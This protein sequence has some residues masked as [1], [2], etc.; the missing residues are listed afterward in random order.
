MWMDE[1]G[2]LA[3]C[4]WLVIWTSGMKKSFD[5]NIL[6]MKVLTP[7]VFNSVQI[8]DYFHMETIKGQNE[9]TIIKLSVNQIFIFS[10]FC[11]LYPTHG[12]CFRRLR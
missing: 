12:T 6:C 5:E 1:L 11:S 4:H 3:A 8:L 7:K 9:T 10:I 2:L